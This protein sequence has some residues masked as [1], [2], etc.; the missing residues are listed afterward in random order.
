V[1]V[2]RKEEGGGS[3]AGS[4]QVHQPVSLREIIRKRATS[5][6][7]EDGQKEIHST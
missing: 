7:G 2:E 4:N 3:S 1:P 5:A 6:R